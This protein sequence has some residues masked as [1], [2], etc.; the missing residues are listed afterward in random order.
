MHFPDTPPP[1]VI[2]A[3]QIRRLR[4]T[5]LLLECPGDKVLYTGEQ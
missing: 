2:F 5:Y 3:L 4:S 1:P